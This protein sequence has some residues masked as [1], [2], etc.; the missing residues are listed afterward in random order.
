MLHIRLSRFFSIVIALALCI[1][2]LPLSAMAQEFLTISEEETAIINKNPHELYIYLGAECSSIIQL[3]YDLCQ[4]DKNEQSVFYDLKSHIESGHIIISYDHAMEFITYTGDFLQQSRDLSNEQKQKSSLQLEEIIKCISD[5]SLTVDAQVLQSME[6]KK[7]KR[8]YTNVAT[9]KGLLSVNDQLVQNITAVD[10]SVTDA[11]IQNLTIVNEITNVTI[12]ALSVI[13]GSVSGTLSVNDE[14]IKTYLRFNDAAGGEYIG[15]QAP[16]T[17]PTSYT[18]SLPSTVPV[19][20]QVLRAGATTPTNLEWFTESGSLSPS[21]SKTI[22]V[23]KYGNDTTG[24]GSFDA[25]YATLAK[26]IDIANSIASAVNPIAIMIS[27]GVYTENNSSGPLSINVQGVSIVGP[28][29]S[30]V[31]ILPNTPANDL[32]LVNDTVRISDVTFKSNSALATGVSLVAGSLSVFTNVRFIGFLTGVNCSGG[33]AETYGF[34]QCLFVANGTGISVDDTRVECNSCSFFGSASTSGPA[35]NTGISVTGANSS[36]VV[37]GGVCALCETGGAITNN[38]QVCFTGISFRQNNSDIVQDGASHLTLASC[39]FEFTSSSSDIDLQVSGAG[40]ITE[41][42]GCEFSGLSTL[43]VAQGLGIKVTDSALVNITGTIMHDYTTAIQVGTPSDTL[44]TELTASSVMIRACTTDVLQ[45]GSATL[46]M[47][48][49]TSSGSKISINDST[50]VQVAFFDLENNGALTIGSM[51]DMNTVLIQPAID[52]TNH[53][54]IDYKSSLYATQAVGFDN[55]ISA[56]NP[57]SLFS[58]SNQNTNLTSITTDRTKVAGVRL[59]SDEGVPVGGTSALR[60]WDINKNASSAELSFQYQNS[61]IT[62]QSVIAEYT[63]MQLD[64]VNNQLQLPA[65]ATQIV[66]ANDTNLYRSSANV[67]KTDDNFIVGTLTPNRAIYT[68][69]ST[70]QLTSS[71]VTSTELGYLSGV[72]SSIQTQLNGKVAKAGDTMT[73]A[74]Q[75]PAGSTASPSLVFTGSTTTGLSSATANTLSF[76]TNAIERM[77]I[78]SSGTIS[79]DAFTT[80]GIVHNDASGNLSSSLIVDADITNAT[81]SNSKLATISSLDVPGAIVVRDGSGNFET[82]MI[83]IDGTVTNPTDVAT[84]AYVD[85]V[86]ATGIVAHTP[87]LVVSNSNV[88]LTGL[89][90][91]DGVTLSAND[92]V[93]LVAQTNP[94][95]NGL[96]LAQ[97]GSW[98]RPTDFAN[99]STAGQAYVLILSGAVYEGSSWLCST[100]TAIIGTDPIQFSLFSLPDVT[101]GANVGSGT[102]LVFKNKTGIT[103]NFRS[104][105]SDTHMSITTNSDDITIGTDATSSNTAS[106]IVARDASGNFSAGTITANLTGSASNNVLKAGDTMTGALQ[107]PTGTTALPSLKFTGSTTTGL[108]ATSDI[109]SFSNAGTESMNINASGVVTIDMF[110]TGGV[111]H[112]N[113]SGNLSS[114]LIVNADVD[115]A[116]AIVDTKLATISTAGKVSNSA[117]TATSTNT[118]NTIVLR[119]GS[120]NFSAGTITASLT[121]AASLNVLKAGDTMTGA[122]QLP[123]GTT[124]NPSLVFTGSTVTGLS[125]SSGDLSFSTDGLE[126]MKIANGGTISIDAFTIPGVVHNDTVGNLSSSLIV[127]ADVDANAAII[128]TKLATISTAGKVANSA[129]TATS[130]N[131]PSTIVL[132]DASGNFSAGRASLTDAVIQNLTITNCLASLC[133]IEL[134]SVDTAIT[135]SLSVTDEVINNSLSIK[136]FSTAGV[137]HNNASGLLSSSLIVNADISA[138]AG[139]VDTKLAT[140]ST[141]GKV[142]NSATTAASSNTANAIVARD[143]SGDFSTTMITLTGTVTNSTD[144]AT[145]EY[146]DIMSLTEKT[147]AF[148]LGT[149]DITLSGLQTIDGESL[150]AGDRVLL[151]NQTNPIENGLWEVQSGSW[152]R[153]TDFNT[154]DTAGTAYVLITDGLTYA[155]SS[156]LCITP[157]AII[158]TDP[159]YFTLFAAASSTTAANVGSGTGLIFRDKT[160][161]TLNLRSLLASNHIAVTNNTNDITIA[162]DATSSNTASTIV[163]R[164]ASGNFSA[165]TIT[166]NLTGSASNNVLKA[167]DTMTGA[168][169]LPAGTTALPSL[170]FTGSPTT[171]LSATSDILSFSNAGVESM[172][173]NASG[174]VTIDMFTTAGVLHNN[175]SGNLSSSLIVNADVD[176]AAAIVDTKLATISTAGKVANSA[177]TGTSSN[178]ANTLVLR[179]N[180]GSFAAQEVSVVDVIASGNIILT[181]DPSSSTAGNIIK[182]SNRFIHDYGTENTFVGLNAGNF[183]LTGTGNTGLGSNALTSVGSGEHNTAIGDNALFAITSANANTAIGY[184]T[185]FSNQTSDNNTAIGYYSLGLTTSGGQNTAVGSAA[186]TNNVSGIANTAVGYNALN[187]NK[188]DGN[189]AVGSTALKANTTGAQ[190]VAFGYQTLLFNTIGSNNTGLGTNAM[191]YSTTGSDNTAVGCVTLFANTTGNYNTGVGSNGLS[192][193]TT[194]NYN[195]AIGYNS[196]LNNTTGSNNTALGAKALMNTSGANNIA[197][198]YQAGQ[199]L[200]TGTGNIYIN[201]DAAT[202][203]ESSTIRIGTSQIQCFVAGVSGVGVSGDVVVVDSNGQFGV[204]LSSERFKHDIQDMADKSDAILQLRPVTF[205][206]NDDETKTIQYGLIAEEV[207]QVFPTI[208]SRDEE[209]KPYTVRYQMLPVLLLNEIQ[210]QRIIIEEI[211][212]HYVTREEMNAALSHI[213]AELQKGLQ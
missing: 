105:L 88:A 179:D 160:G 181:T 13:D 54:S 185:L 17:V 81:I 125:A 5:G 122:L 196:L 180:T 186:L 16:V 22:Y 101:T 108:S 76:S 136:P 50:N 104:L 9:I 47:N 161:I 139:I 156:Y 128:D 3:L 42:I 129:T 34:N 174:V 211:K 164:D 177:T 150:F 70:N 67:L 141:A 149:Y 176:P 154:G 192:S 8:S 208:V 178:T 109:L 182:G 49:C 187:N 143:S 205:A 127:N 119:D 132:R 23:A 197:I 194:G 201:A 110:T 71:A 26:A 79:I 64:G 183:T 145:K 90:T 29:S 114:S 91:I 207:D 107:L 118:A 43:S 202:S 153:P 11:T 69:S 142:A 40:T 99:G 165:G 45:Q 32:L 77:K 171:G 130:G 48:A 212:Q 200:T 41:V 203:S 28:S 123:A 21:T 146:V 137:V 46:E 93:L 209:G 30:S 33:A 199:T 189:T 2:P 12:D 113:A 103:L 97:S 121:G 188:T 155:G 159:I 51:S 147:P 4:F 117:T 61:D 168:L 184:N 68:D 193:N 162:T 62:G 20:Y 15:L 191:T 24:N 39:T 72:T 19:A 213:K 35:A 36:I 144:A 52:P 158:D 86:A 173:I 53:P 84:K 63:V 59:V 10:L 74:L 66:F 131:N 102:G 195:T 14:I 120:G 27:S 100:P 115:P 44:S 7:I 38:A 172:N 75:L 157:T 116:A 60:G 83:T 112:N 134:S 152:T 6:A 89:Q 56:T 198:G 166:A 65:T 169:Q 210:K 94:V 167:G 98:T 206:Y 73:G 148:V 95:E 96:W 25:P 111:V 151:T 31:I 124:S 190:N 85:T 138:S 135:G 106:T 37:D 175:S 58:L 78:S 126:R 57:T 80:A 18:V 133:A 82:N 55:T 204:T 163:A 170:K 92:R 1:S 87:A 140:I